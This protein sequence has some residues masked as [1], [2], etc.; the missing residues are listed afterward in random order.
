MPEIT[1]RILGVHKILSG[2]RVDKV[3]GPNGLGISKN[4]EGFC[5]TALKLI[6]DNLSARVRNL[7]ST[8]QLETIKHIADIIEEGDIQTRKYRP[9]SLACIG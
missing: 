9:V 1:I 8:I 5:D 2:M 3:W 4:P 7:H 6:G